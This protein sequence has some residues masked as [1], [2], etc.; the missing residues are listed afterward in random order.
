MP[1]G[2]GFDCALFIS[3]P[4][5]TV[6]YYGIGTQFGHY[7]HFSDPLP[8]SRFYKCREISIDALNDQAVDLLNFVGTN[9]SK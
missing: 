6:I 5:R 4:D 9:C 1:D 8:T 3:T 7:R 2:Q